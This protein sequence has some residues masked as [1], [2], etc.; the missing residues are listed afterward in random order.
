MTLL[1][2]DLGLLCETLDFRAILSGTPLPIVARYTPFGVVGLLFR[3]A[4]R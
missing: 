4:E 1:V 3:I 2:L